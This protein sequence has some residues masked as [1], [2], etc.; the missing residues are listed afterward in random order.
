MLTLTKSLAALVIFAAAGTA[1][2]QPPVANTDAPTTV[3]RF[4][5]LDIRSPA[6]LQALKARIHGAASRLCTR[7]DRKPLQVELAERRCMSVA[8]ASAQA[9]IDKALA[10]GSVRMASGSKIELSER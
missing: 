2:A 3:V 5:D 10:Q 1:A 9:G 6:G 4:A 8:T 7:N